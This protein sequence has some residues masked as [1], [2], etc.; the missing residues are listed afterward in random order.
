MRSA[1]SRVGRRGGAGE[2]GVV[3]GRRD[4]HPVLSEHGADRLDAEPVT[5]SVEVMTIT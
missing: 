1:C 2:V 4:L 5:R 3:G